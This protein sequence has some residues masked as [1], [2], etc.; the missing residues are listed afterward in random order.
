MSTDTL[1]PPADKSFGVKHPIAKRLLQVVGQ[2]LFLGIILFAS[3]GTLDW[4]WAWVYFAAG[5]A[6]LIVNAIV[7]PR[8]LIAERGAAKTNVKTWDKWIALAM[9]VLSILIYLIA[10]LDM[11]FDWSPEMALALHSGGLIGFVAGSLLFTW[12]MVSN[13]FFSTA[14]RIQSDRGQ[15]VET[16]GPYR[17]VRHP[18]YV[19]YILW[20]LATPFLLGSWC[21]LGPAFLLSVT[22]IVRTALEDKTLW[23]ELDGYTEYAARVR[24]RLV[25]GVW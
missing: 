22:M 13:H 25:P 10:G 14:V 12:A 6:I 2:Y 17:L 5:I 3:A 23:Q 19:G 4:I 24:Y 11:R 7:M 1:T 21:A 16:G 15:K 20:T 8:E 18:G 9:L